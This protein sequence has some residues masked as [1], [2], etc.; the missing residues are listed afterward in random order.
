[1]DGLAHVECR[2]FTALPAIEF[3]PK[4]FQRSS[5]LDFVSLIRELPQRVS[6]VPWD[7]THRFIPCAFYSN[8]GKSVGK[9]LH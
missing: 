4:R 7:R 2:D 1:M 5:E 8:I 6:D 9:S 3:I